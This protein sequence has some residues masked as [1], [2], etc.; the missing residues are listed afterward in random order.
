MVEHKSDRSPEAGKS[1]KWILLV[2]VVLL[3]ACGGG[4][5]ALV[6]IFRGPT[7]DPVLLSIEPDELALLQPLAWSAEVDRVESSESIR[8][9][10]APLDDSAKRYVT[11]GIHVKSF[12]TQLA[13]KYDFLSSIRKNYENN[14]GEEFL[15]DIDDGVSLLADEFDI[16]CYDTDQRYKRTKNNCDWWVYWARYG[17][18]RVFVRVTGSDWGRD[19]FVGLIAEIDAKI[20][21]KMDASP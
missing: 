9:W 7:Q 1:R 21:E 15:F 10:V 16:F 5:I 13:A 20:S 14:S 18:Y 3:V 11:F 8:S 4:A 19:E 2:G 17:D 6:S 12:P